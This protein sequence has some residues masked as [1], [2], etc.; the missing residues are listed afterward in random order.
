SLGEYNSSVQ[1]QDNIKLMQTMI[2]RQKKLIDF[3]LEEMEVK[4]RGNKQV[5]TQEFSQLRTLMDRYH[6]MNKD[7][8]DW[9]GNGKQK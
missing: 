9:T 6:Q 1:N 8:A 4:R 7:M 3:K 5:T 2:D